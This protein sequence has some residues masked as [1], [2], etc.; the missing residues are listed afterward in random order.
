MS[1]CFMHFLKNEHSLVFNKKNTKAI[2]DLIPIF[3]KFT[4][5]LK[6]IIYIRNE[7][8]KGH[9]SNG[10]EGYLLEEFRRERNLSWNRLEEFLEDR[11]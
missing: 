7:F 4:I 8:C 6:E 10:G 3:E 2:V 5:S 1:A 9:V 11:I